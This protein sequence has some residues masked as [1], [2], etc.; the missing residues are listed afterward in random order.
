MR[1]NGE[2]I[3]KKI[4]DTYMLIPVLDKNVSMKSIFD[5]NEVGNF[6]FEQIKSLK[7]RDEILT[8]LIKEYNAPKETLEKDLDEYIG[9]LIEKRIVIND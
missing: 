2:F 5:M 4:G 1:L 7:S 8:E 9:L 3:V 6:I